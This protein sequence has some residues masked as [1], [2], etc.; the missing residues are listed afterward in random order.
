[1]T[2]I[3][4][5]LPLDR[6]ATS[7]PARLGATSPWFYVALTVGA[8]LWSAPLVVLFF[9]AVKTPADFSTNGT[10]AWPRTFEPANFSEAWRLGIKTYFMNSLVLTVLKVPTGVFICSL[11]AF[12][13]AKMRMRGANALFT[14]ALLGLIVPMQM[15]LV[16]LTILYQSIGAID[17]LAGLF[18]LYLGFGLPI[19]I[20]VLRG[21]FRNIPNEL[22]EAAFID[23][24]SWWGVYWRIVM[25]LAKPALVSLLILDSISTWN[26]FILA[27]IF[28]RTESQ[29]TLPLGVVMFSGEFS[30][31]YNLLAAGQL[32]TI[33][34]VL[35]LY[36]FFQRYFVHGLGG[37]VK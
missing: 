8:L 10:F 12:A 7:R 25:P 33:V 5:A 6:T 20:L 2:A 27:Q 13:I 29:R 21:F 30:T 35:A 15:T 24:C 36:L 1:M 31:Q 3:G 4:A 11:A 32:M 28:L 26:E 18:F 37:A 22:M 14:I 34:P 23:G 9:T 17:S 19:G 16:P